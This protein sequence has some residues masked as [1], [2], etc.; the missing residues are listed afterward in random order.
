MDGFSLS[1]SS[2]RDAAPQFSVE[3]HR[4]T[5]ALGTLR[6]TLDSLGQPWGHDHQ[7]AEFASQYESIR[8]VV[9]HA[10]DLLAQG[11]CSID[12]CL[13]ASADSHEQREHAATVRAR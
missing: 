7:M 6:A 1:T 11:V 8:P 9:E 12:T 10:I 4:L 13:A 2:L 5:E 3:G